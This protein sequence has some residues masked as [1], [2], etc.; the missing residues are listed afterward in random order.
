MSK[1]KITHEGELDIND[2]IIPCYV[3][4]DGTRVLSGRG[5]QDALK[6]VEDFED[7]KQ[8]SGARLSRYLDQKT[9]Q[10]YIYKDKEVGHYKAIECLKG[11]SKINGT[12]IENKHK[13]NE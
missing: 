8:K 5:V 11:N 9:L 4:E 3:L 7:S 6:M 10:P 13:N 12:A 1:H 2:I